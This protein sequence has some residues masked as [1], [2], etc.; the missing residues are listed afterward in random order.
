MGGTENK[1]ISS[2]IFYKNNSTSFVITHLLLL[3][4][5][6]LLLPL[7]DLSCYIHNGIVIVAQIGID[8]QSTHIGIVIRS[9][10]III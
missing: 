4:I 5:L 9:N 1:G 2:I 7:F 8:I 3:L 10:R 6:L